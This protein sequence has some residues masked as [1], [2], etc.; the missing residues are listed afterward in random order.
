M[1]FS[2]VISNKGIAPICDYIDHK[3]YI[4]NGFFQNSNV[5]HE[6]VYDMQGKF[7]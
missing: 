3:Q 1:Y 6:F 5:Q 4:I 2:E 7:C